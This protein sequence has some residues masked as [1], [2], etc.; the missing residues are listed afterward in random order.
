MKRAYLLVY[1]ATLGTREQ[2][3]T[4]LNELPEV[5]TWRHDLPNAYYIISEADPRP[6]A[7]AIRSC[8]GGRG[9]F[10]LVEVTESK[11]GYLPSESWFFLRHKKRKLKS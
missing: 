7:E 8:R 4:C 9:R 3:K 10:I 1:S 2:V 6:L 11:A 5:I